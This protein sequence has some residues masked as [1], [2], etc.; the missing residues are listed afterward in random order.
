M[1]QTVENNK[2]DANNDDVLQ[3]ITFK[4]GKEEFSVSI[5]KVQEIIRITDITSI[6]NSPPFVDGIINLRGNVIP[7][8]DSRKR[9]G[10]PEAERTDASRVIVVES[11]AKIVGLIVDSVTEVLQLP[12]NTVEPPPDIV[13]GVD[14]DYIDGVGKYDERLVILLNLEKVLNFKEEVPF[15]EEERFEDVATVAAGAEV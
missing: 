1:S 11:G 14:S 15:K 6:P 8:I 9:F 10:L 4:V 12:K 3:I 5:H 13:G 2:A 7:V